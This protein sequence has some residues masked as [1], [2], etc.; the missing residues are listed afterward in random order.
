MKSADHLRKQHAELLRIAAEVE[1]LLDA[2]RLVTSWTE[3]RLKL[4]AFARKL[5]VHFALEDRFIYARLSRH[6][7]PA[8]SNKATEHRNQMIE[9]RGRATRHADRWLSPETAIETTSAEFVE[10]TK[11][12]LDLVSKRCDLEDRE[13]YT[14]VDQICSPSGKWPLD[15]SADD[16]QTR[17][18]G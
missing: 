13:I 3:V 4:T 10:Q 15:L 16:D 1:P 11:G 17:Q 9:L 6:A 2:E 5:D 7:D 12:I 8:I 18:A 14:L